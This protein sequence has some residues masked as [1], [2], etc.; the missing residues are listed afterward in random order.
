MDVLDDIS[1]L[2]LVHWRGFVQVPMNF[3]HSHIPSIVLDIA[4]PV[5]LT[6]VSLIR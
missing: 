1:V 4:I 3:L 6:H 5:V 2:G